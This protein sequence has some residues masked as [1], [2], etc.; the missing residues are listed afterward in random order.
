M[1]QEG[2][3]EMSADYAFEVIEAPVTPDE[4]Y[5][6]WPFVDTSVTL[7]VCFL[8]LSMYLYARDRYLRLKQNLMLASEASLA[9]SPHGSNGSID[10]DRPVEL[11]PG[12]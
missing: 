11:R 9:T 5:S 1:Q 2:M 8:I 3:A 12:N 7:V 4:I 10:L 6:P